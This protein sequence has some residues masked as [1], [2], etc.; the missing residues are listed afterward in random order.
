MSGNRPTVIDSLP[1]TDAQAVLQTIPEP[2]PADQRVPPRSGAAAVTGAAIIA[3]S[4]ATDSAGTANGEPPVPAPTEPLG[5]RPSSSSGGAASTPPPPPPPPV[6]GGSS[7]TPAECWRVQLA[8]VPEAER[9]ERLKS[10]AESQ[11]SVPCA[12]VK[13]KTLYKVRTRECEDSAAAEAIR[14][15]AVADGFSGA[16]KIRDSGK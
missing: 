1:T 16:F 2:L 5:D 6:V 13:E 12:I 3:D 9:A 4:T 15:R 8:A 11:L 7:A 10:A 14:K